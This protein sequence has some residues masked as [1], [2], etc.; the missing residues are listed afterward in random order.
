[1]LCQENPVTVPTL[2]PQWIE[3]IFCL[4][5]TLIKDKHILSTGQLKCESWSPI[6]LFLTFQSTNSKKKKPSSIKCSVKL[7]F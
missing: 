6:Y 3:L 7:S 5:A 4:F 1:M 2:D